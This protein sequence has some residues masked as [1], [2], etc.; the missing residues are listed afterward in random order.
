MPWVVTPLIF[1]FTDLPPIFPVIQPHLKLK[2]D[3]ADCTRA[4]SKEQSVFE[5]QPPLFHLSTFWFY[6]LSLLNWKQR[7]FGFCLCFY[8]KSE[9]SSCLKFELYRKEKVKPITNNFTNPWNP[10]AL[11]WVLLAHRCYRQSSHTYGCCLAH[12]ISTLSRHSG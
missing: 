9:Y 11:L 6:S 5:C 4:V 1:Q 10:L 2:K 8:L 12:W 3:S 7:E